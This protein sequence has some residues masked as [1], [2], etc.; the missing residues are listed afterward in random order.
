MEIK[1]QFIARYSK[2]LEILS[3]FLIM[4]LI[5]KDGMNHSVF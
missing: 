3:I 2:I 4:F 1:N 5:K